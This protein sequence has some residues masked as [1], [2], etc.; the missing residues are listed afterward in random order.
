MWNFWRGYYFN[1]IGILIKRG[2]LD[3]HTCTHTHSGRMP[4]ENM[5][6]EI[7]KPRNAQ[8]SRKPSEA[9]EQAWTDVL[10]PLPKGTNHA[11]TVILDFQPPEIRSLHYLSL[12]LSYARLSKLMHPFL[13]PKS[14]V[15][16]IFN[17]KLSDFIPLFYTSH[18][19][20]FFK[21]Q[22]IRQNLL[23]QN[24]TRIRNILSIKAPKM[25]PIHTFVLRTTGRKCEAIM[26]GWLSLRI[27]RS[28]PSFCHSWEPHGCDF[29][30]GYTLDSSGE[31]LKTTI[32]GWN[33]IK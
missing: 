30:L 29:N 4:W 8:D 28:M 27:W 26:P 24:H 6:A 21:T 13:T 16:W 15:N 1:I 3:T 22:M 18:L 32:A 23:N 19:W 7:Y 5:Q 31:L 9:R 10:S 33:Q 11:D 14:W 17:I 2:N 12:W 20:R 25:K